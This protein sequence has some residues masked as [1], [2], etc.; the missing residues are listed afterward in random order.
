VIMTSSEEKKNYEKMS[1]SADVVESQL[2]AILTEGMSRPKSCQRSQF[3]IKFLTYALKK[4]NEI[5]K[6]RLRVFKTVT[7]AA[8]LS[9]TGTTPFFVLILFQLLITPPTLLNS[10][11]CAEITQNVIGSLREAIE[12]L[13]STFFY[14]RSFKCFRKA[15]HTFVFSNL[16]CAFAFQFDSTNLSFPIDITSLSI[17]IINSSTIESKEILIYTVLTKQETLIIWTP[18]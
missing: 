17:L 5:S 8:T 2:P 10:A 3:L 6:C 12:W 11:I 18:C 16:P 14:I 7:V 9:S 13:K 15:L 4:I 1:L